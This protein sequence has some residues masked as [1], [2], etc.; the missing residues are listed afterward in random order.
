MSLAYEG[1]PADTLQAAVNFIFPSISI[2][3]SPPPV[4]GIGFRNGAFDYAGL[5]VNFPPGAAAAAVPRSEPEARGGPVPARPACDDGRTRV[6]VASVIGIDGTMMIALASPQKPFTLPSGHRAGRVLREIEGRRLT[7]FAFAIGAQ[8]SLLTPAGDI[9]LSERVTSSTTTPSFL[10]LDGGWRFRLGGDS[11]PYVELKGGVG[12][13]ANIDPRRFNV[14]GNNEICFGIPTPPPFADMELCQGV[15][16]LDLEPWRVRVREEHR[17]APVPAVLRS[18]D[19]ARLDVGRAAA[20]PD[21][22]L[23]SCQ[24]SDYRE[25]QPPIGAA[26]GWQRRRRCAFDPAARAALGADARGAARRRRAGRG[27]AGAGRHPD[28]RAARR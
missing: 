22:T 5:E 14:E 3:G 4:R 1:P 9:P 12:G 19:R 16:G 27:R 8:A 13:W 25:V 21:I 24:P 11:A 28:Q 18:G 2:L 20:I 23:F 15:L 10:E 17:H 7:S 26:G 6:S